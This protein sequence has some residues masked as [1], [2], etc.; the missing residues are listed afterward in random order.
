MI[1]WSVPFWGWHGLCIAPA[2]CLCVGVYILLLFELLAGG[3]AETSGLL[4][5][6]GGTASAQPLVGVCVWVSLRASGLEVLQRF[7]FVVANLPRAL[8]CLET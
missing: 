7:L 8:T 3:H 1:E 5:F 6:G 2:G 4:L